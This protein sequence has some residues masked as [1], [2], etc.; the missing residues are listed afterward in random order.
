MHLRLLIACSLCLFV[1][2]LV[3]I[4]RAADE[5]AKIQV[6][7]IAGD[8]VAPYHDWR[9]ISEATSGGSIALSWPISALRALS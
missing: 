9:E 8:D 3:T 1:V 2:P 7:L 4:A 6:L 5:P